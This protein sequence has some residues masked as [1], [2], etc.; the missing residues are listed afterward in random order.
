[1]VEGRLELNVPTKVALA[2]E[3]GK[4]CGDTPQ[5]AAE[6]EWGLG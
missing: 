2:G 6:D 3:R 1:M 5:A 4:C